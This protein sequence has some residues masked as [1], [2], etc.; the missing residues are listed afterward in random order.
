MMASHLVPAPEEYTNSRIWDVMWNL[1]CQAWGT[2]CQWKHWNK[3]LNR[4]FSS[5]WAALKM[6]K[7]ILFLHVWK[8]TTSHRNDGEKPRM[9]GLCETLLFPW[10]RSWNLSRQVPNLT[11]NE[12]NLDKWA[13][14]YEVRSSWVGTTDANH[15]HTFGDPSKTIEKDHYAL[16]AEA[17]ALVCCT[18]D[19]N[20]KALASSSYPSIT[21]YRYT[22]KQKSRRG[23]VGS[24]VGHGLQFLHI[25]DKEIIVLGVLWTSCHP[26]R[27]NYH[28]EPKLLVSGRAATWI[29]VGP[30]VLTVKPQNKK[31][32]SFLDGQVQFHWFHW[33]SCQYLPQAKLKLPSN[34]I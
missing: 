13:F 28:S 21:N 10:Y 12:K 24:A 23:Q 25:D 18:S 1:R 16:E 14:I 11:K 22:R 30:P 27:W 32:R 4:D 34:T 20:L 17:T 8:S 9:T 15:R 33:E 5:L 3:F 19:W 29:E 2:L 7:W 26:H 31:H 6:L